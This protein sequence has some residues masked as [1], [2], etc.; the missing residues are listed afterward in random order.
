MHFTDD[1]TQLLQHSLKQNSQEDFIDNSNVALR[2]KFPNV[3]ERILKVVLEKVDIND[4]KK[5]EML[6]KGLK[7]YIKAGDSTNSAESVNQKRG[8]T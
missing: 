5:Q 2:D 4:Y 7:K 8:K 3:F 1:R 6:H